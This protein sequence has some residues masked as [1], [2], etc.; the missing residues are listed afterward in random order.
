MKPASSQAKRATRFASIAVITVILTLAAI[1][2]IVRNATTQKDTQ[3]FAPIYHAAQAM[4]EGRNIYAATSGLYIYP[5]FLAFLFQPLALFPERAAAIVWV[6]ASAVLI[7]VAALIAANEVTRRWRLSVDGD[8][9]VVWLIAAGGIFLAAEKIHAD[10]RLGQTDCLMILGFACVLRWMNCQPWLAGLAVGATANMKYLSL[11][12]LPYFVMKRNIR[13]AIASLLSFAMLMIL[14]ALE[15]GVKEATQFA[16]SAVGALVKMTDLR[17]GLAGHGM[18]IPR[19]SWP[20]SVSITSAIIRF[21]R[22]HGLPD[23]VPVIFVLI[24]LAAVIAAILIISR[25]HGVPLFSLGR[26]SSSPAAEAS[27]SLEWASLVVIALTFSPQTTARHMVLLLL[28]Y[29]VALGVLLAQHDR[30]SRFVLASAMVITF[31]GLSF[32]PR[33]VGMD[34]LLWAWRGIAGASLCAICLLLVTLQYGC[35]T[36][37]SW[38]SNARKHTE[39]V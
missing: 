1:P 12:L 36:I 10:F 34:E 39:S 18:K 5:P 6:I 38:S 26:S 16:E 3:D 19:A 17:P 20:R 25:R 2:T 37:Q 11:I 27:A 30:R 13:A 23:W 22:A 32:P 9:S 15:V 35:R 24:A 14:P 29:I 4:L 21:G 28:V 7:V 31:L 8:S 33:K